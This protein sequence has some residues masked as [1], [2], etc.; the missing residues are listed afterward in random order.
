[1]LATLVAQPFDRDGWI[2]EIKWD[3]YR[4]IGEVDGDNVFLYSRRQESFAEKFAPIHDALAKLGHNAILDGEVVVLDDDG[5]PS[6]QALQNYQKFGQGNLVYCIFD[7]LSLDGQDL[8]ALPLVH[9]KELLQDLPLPDERLRIS[10]HVEHDGV[11]FFQAAVEQGLEGIVAKNG[12]SPY[13]EGMR[14]YDWLKIKSRQRQEAVIAGFTKPRGSRV[15]FGSLI[16]GVHEQGR[17][18]FIGHTGTGFDNRTLGDLHQQLIDRAQPECPFAKRPKTNTR[19]TWV[20]PELVCEIEFHGWTDDGIMRQP[21]FLGLRTDKPAG[22]I[23]R[24]R[25][26]DAKKALAQA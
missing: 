8:R 4:A 9:R 11:A 26:K 13:R 18:V 2:Y 1:M 14:S 24:E 20:R 21:V 6:F 7:L 23:V 16:L 3:G 5:R 19:P 15:G 10:D 12:K 22:V 17:L 25:P